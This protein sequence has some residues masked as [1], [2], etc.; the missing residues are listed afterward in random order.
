MLLKCP[1]CNKDLRITGFEGSAVHTACSGCMSAATPESKRPPPKI[2]INRVVMDSGIDE[3]ISSIH[4]TQRRK[5]VRRKWGGNQNVPI[6]H[7]KS[8]HAL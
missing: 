7:R 4:E 6:F 8:A 5:F 1:R 3:I 2:S